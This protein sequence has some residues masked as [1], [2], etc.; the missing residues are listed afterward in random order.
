MTSQR[1]TCHCAQACAH[2]QTHT[3]MHTQEC[4]PRPQY[5]HIFFIFSTPEKLLL[6][7]LK[8][9]DKD[10]TLKTDGSYWLLLSFLE[11]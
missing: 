11:V 7:S 5:L 4:R 6:F 10:F 8:S 3:H 2:T 1:A 9:G